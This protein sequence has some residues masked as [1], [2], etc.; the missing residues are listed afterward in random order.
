MNSIIITSLTV[1]ACIC[2]YYLKNEKNTYSTLVYVINLL[3]F[4]ICCYLFLSKLIYRVNTPEVWDFT[5]FYLWGKEAAEGLNFYLPENANHVFNSLA[6]PS[7]NY[8]EFVKD[9]VNVGFLYPPPTILYF[10]PLG[11]L[12]YNTA[13]I[14]WILFNLIFLLGCIYLIYSMFLKAEKLKGLLLVVTLV[15]LFSPV[16]ATVFYSQTNFILLFYLLLMKK[17]SE[18]KFAGI[19]LAL[20]IFTK[21]YTIIFLLF[22]IIIKNWRAII[23][24]I[25]TSFALV[26]LTAAIFGTAPFIS[27][28]FDNPSRRLPTGTYFEEINQS[29]HAVLLRAKLISID[30][31]LIF[32]VIIAVLL[33]VTLAYLIY[34]QKRKLYNYMWAV[35]LL[36]G[37]MLYPGTLNHYLV[38][39]LFIIF[40]FF[41]KK[42]MWFNSFITVPITGIFYFLS[43]N[44][45][46]AAICFLLLVIIIKS[47]YHK[48]EIKNYK[49]AIF[50]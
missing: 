48:T 24:F 26:G 6:L 11:Y 7:L 29:L 41:D 34:L 5:A 15:F 27:Y 32:T 9:I 39:V 37:L 46:F 38:L 17:Y 47:I 8:D 3:V 35:L 20:A 28:I 45:G 16:R 21:P 12:S 44:W 43:T 13:L 50:T 36:I 1:I 25:L 23:Y 31:P 40:Q 4:G 42:Q 22:F 49:L 19:F 18:T 10:I 2:F 30:K 33:I 14:C